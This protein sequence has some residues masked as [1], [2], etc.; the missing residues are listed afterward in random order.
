M[1]IMYIFLKTVIRVSDAFDETIV[2]SFNK[3]ILLILSVYY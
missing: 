1:Y 2:N 3:I